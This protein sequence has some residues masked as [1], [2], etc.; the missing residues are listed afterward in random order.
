MKSMLV[1]RTVLASVAIGA[2]LGSAQLR[3]RQTCQGVNGKILNSSHDPALGNYGGMGMGGV[4]TFGVVALN[5]GNTHGKL[6]CALVGVQGDSGES[7]LSPALP[8]LPDFTH[9]I[10]CDDR[11]EGGVVHSQLTFDTSGYFTGFDGV[12]TLY[13]T[14]TSIPRDESGIG[15]C[16]GTSSSNSSLTIEGTLNFLNTVR[17]LPFRL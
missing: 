4:S 8:V 9:T 16:A 11:V 2:L 3:A 5:G 6:K 10:S 17:L 12:S 1:A 15:A 13:F 7:P 14:E